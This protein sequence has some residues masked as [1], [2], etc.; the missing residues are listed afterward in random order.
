MKNKRMF[1]LKLRLDLKEE[2]SQAQLSMNSQKDE[3]NLGV[4]TQEDFQEE[5]KYES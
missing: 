3:R 4:V 5:I 2:G 1:P